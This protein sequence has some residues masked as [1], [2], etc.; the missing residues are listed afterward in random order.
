MTNNVENFQQSLSHRFANLEL[1]K[2]ALTHRS[3][4]KTNNE[5]FEFLGDSL[6]GFVVAELLYQEFPS[7]SEGELSRM[8]SSMV[9]KPALAAIARQLELGS[10]LRLGSGERNSGGAARDS[11][12]SDAVEAIIAAIYLDGGI[13]ACKKQVRAWAF[14]QINVQNTLKESKDPK[15]QLQELMQA[16]GLALPQYEVVK[17]EGVAHDQTFTISCSVASLENTQLGIGR[18]KRAAEQEA[19]AKLLTELSVESD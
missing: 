3:A 17:V 4:E 6:L 1:L 12:L 11:I 7:A 15:T 14:A 19:A 8:R 2:Q 9:S 13:D 10:F 16:K 18:S 5:R